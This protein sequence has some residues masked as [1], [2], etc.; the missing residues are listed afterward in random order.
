MAAEVIIN[1]VNITAEAVFDYSE[2]LGLGLLDKHKLKVEVEEYINRQNRSGRLLRDNYFRCRWHDEDSGQTLM[3][4]LYRGE[5]MSIIQNWDLA[6]VCLA[7]DWDEDLEAAG[8]VRLWLEKKTTNLGTGDW[9]YEQI[10]RAAADK[11]I[12]GSAPQGTL[13]GI[14]RELQNAIEYGNNQDLFEA[15][16]ILQNAGGK[17]ARRGVERKAG[18]SRKID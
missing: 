15:V 5:R 16:H 9:V 2:S 4:F 8:L 1:K 11:I 3:L 6:G 18:I 7:N 10:A 14:P 17:R 13:Q 12:I